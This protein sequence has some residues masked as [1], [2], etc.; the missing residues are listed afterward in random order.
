M[1]LLL[2][3]AKSDW[4]QTGLP[5]PD[6]PLARRGLRDAPRMGRLL[7][8]RGLVPARALA[9]PAV[10]ARE[11]ARLVLESAGAP[12]DSLRLVPEL[13]GSS[14]EGI[15]AIARESDASPLLVVAHNPGLEDLVARFAGSWSPFPTAAL[16]VVSGGRLEALFRPRDADVP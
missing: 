3:H 1:L 13:Y 16:A 5:D 10:R 4:G 14:A 6:R 8:E 9:S 7:R 11:T 15:L 2:R 12:A